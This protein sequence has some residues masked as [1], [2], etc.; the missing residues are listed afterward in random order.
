MKVATIGF[1]KKSAEEFFGLLRKAEVRTLVDIRLKNASQ[2]AGFAQGRDLP[3]FLRELVG[4]DYVH[5]PALAPTPELL[6][7]YRDDQDWDAY[8]RDFSIHLDSAPQR[9]A[10]AA[11]FDLGQP[12]CLLC[13]EDLPEKCHRRLV[14]ERLQA[15]DPTVEIV[16]LS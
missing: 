10:M 15:E 9:E 1:T 11:L 13:S 14:A 6:T 8:E 3:F 16:H 4:V 5:I 7:R 2:L 12:I